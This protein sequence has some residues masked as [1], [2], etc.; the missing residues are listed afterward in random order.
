MLKFLIC[1]EAVLSRRKTTSVQTVF[2]EQDDG[3]D[4]EYGDFISLFG[5]TA[6]HGRGSYYS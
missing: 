3:R 5:A 2:G 6:R 4:K 1:C